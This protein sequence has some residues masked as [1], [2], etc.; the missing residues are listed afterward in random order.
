MSKPDS[1]HLCKNRVN[2]H[3]LCVE[4]VALNCYTFGCSSPEICS[5]VKVL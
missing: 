1:S 3:F 5:A 4:V 2:I